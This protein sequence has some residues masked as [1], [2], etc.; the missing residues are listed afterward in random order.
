MAEE[1]GHGNAG[2]GS[3][4]TGATASV[5]GEHAAGEDAANRSGDAAAACAAALEA[6]HERA[7]AETSLSDVHSH[8]SYE[9]RRNALISALAVENAAQTQAISELLGFVQAVNDTDRTSGG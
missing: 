5:P 7:A 3:S 2:C 9:M 8:R 4:A 1:N 6:A